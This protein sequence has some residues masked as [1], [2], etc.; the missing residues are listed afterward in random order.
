MCQLC[1]CVCVCVRKDDKLPNE[2]TFHQIYGTAFHL[3]RLKSAYS[4]PMLRSKVKCIGQSL[5]TR[6]NVLASAKTESGLGKNQLCRSVDWNDRTSLNFTL[7]TDVTN[8]QP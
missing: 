2:M 4:R 7:Q 5:E 8:S 1:V 3:D 6:K